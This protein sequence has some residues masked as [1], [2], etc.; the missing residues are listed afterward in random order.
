MTRGAE[1]NSTLALDSPQA[2]VPASVE[3]VLNPLWGS[4][5][6]SHRLS[7]R[8]A[9]QAN[10]GGD[11]AILDLT[12]LPKS[13]SHSI[14]ISQL[15]R[16]RRVCNCSSAVRARVRCR[17]QRTCGTSEIARVAFE[18]AEVAESPTPNAFWAVKEAAF[19]SLEGCCQPRGL[20]DLRVGSWSQ[21]EPG[22]FRCVML[23]VAHRGFIGISGVVIEVGVLPMRCFGVRL[24]T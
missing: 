20:K 7:L 13:A 9:I 17:G 18:P 21:T 3:I 12:R 2:A 16:P 1:A 22:V 8:A 19:K 14:S 10:V 5:K 23:E 11:A 15:Q 4:Q 24:L 6:P